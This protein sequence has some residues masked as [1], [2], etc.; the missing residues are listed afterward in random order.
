MLLFKSFWFITR[1][2]RDKSNIALIQ[3]LLVNKQVDYYIKFETNN[4]SI[5]IEDQS[6]WLIKSIDLAIR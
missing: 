3:T 5:S 2:L 6:K 1:G 4:I